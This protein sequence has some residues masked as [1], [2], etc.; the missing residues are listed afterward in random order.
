MPYQLLVEEIKK[1]NFFWNKIKKDEGWFGGTLDVPFEAAQATSLSF[2]ALTA[3]DDIHEHSE[4]LG[5]V[6]TMPELW[7][8]ML[9][10][11]KDLD[12]HTDMEKSFLQILMTKTR[13]TTT[14]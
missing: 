1:K 7:G 10:N 2:G 5:T 8:T 11:E 4:V 12:R 6:S 13:R 14:K 9:F 3:A